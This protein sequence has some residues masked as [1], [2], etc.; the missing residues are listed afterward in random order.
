MAPR[1]SL[2]GDVPLERA[3]I[4]EASAYSVWSRGYGRLLLSPAT[5]EAPN[6]KCNHESP[7]A[8]SNPR[9]SHVG[10]AHRTPFGLNQSTGNVC[11]PSSAPKVAEAFRAYDVAEA[12]VLPD[13]EIFVAELRQLQEMARERGG[14]LVSDRYLGC[15]IAEWKCGNPDHPSW[16][17]EPWRI[18]KGAWCPSCAGNRRLSLDDFRSWGKSV[19]LELL[20]AEYRGG[21][22]TPY[23]WRCAAGHLIE[24]PRANILR[25][26]SKGMGPCPVCGGT[27]PPNHKP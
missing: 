9:P 13:G 20:D 3:R 4:D 6:I 14:T 2:L 16:Q 1:S 25:S 8:P 22:Q 5:S 26:L 18:R 21:A 27:R 11:L 7:Y 24:R 19:G 12:P 10:V 23:K 17:A 15:E